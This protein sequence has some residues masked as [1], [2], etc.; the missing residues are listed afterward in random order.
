N[1]SQAHGPIVSQITFPS[2]VYTWCI[3]EMLDKHKAG[4]YMYDTFWAPPGRHLKFF[5]VFSTLIAPLCA[6]LFTEANTV[7]VYLD[8][9]LLT[10]FK[11]SIS[12]LQDGKQLII[13]PETEVADNA[14]VNRFHEPF[15]DLGKLYYK[16]TG[17]RLAFVPTYICPERREIH[18]GKPVF[19]DPKNTPEEERT[20][21]T[22]YLSEQICETARSLPTHTVVPFLNTATPHK[23]NE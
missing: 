8:K 9:R 20:R 1:H 22:R 15:V 7:P 18:T 23:N 16:K 14:I 6:L 2:S 21:I 5:R 12:L 3:S 11:K 4:D 13:F 10:T 17:K 19:Y